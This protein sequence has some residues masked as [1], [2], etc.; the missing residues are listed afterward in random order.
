M[1][2]GLLVPVPE[3]E[4]IVGSWRARYDESAAKGVPAHITVLVPFVPPD[5]IDERLIEDLWELFA[6]AEPFSCSYGT[7]A[8]FDDE[9]IYLAPEPARPFVELIERIVARYPAYPPYGGIHDVIVPHLTIGLAELG[10]PFDEID[11][12]VRPRLPIRAQ[13]REVWLMQGDDHWETRA[14]IPLGYS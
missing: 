7:T 5:D 10:A 2:S 3:A 8:R 6:Q 1:E 14:V 11:R 9:V 4:P 12:D 13:A